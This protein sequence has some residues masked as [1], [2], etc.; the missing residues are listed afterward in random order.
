MGNGPA[1]PSQPSPDQWGERLTRRLGLW[2]AVAVL[3]GS[4]IGSGI[5]RT[6]AVIADRVPSAVPML[7]VWVLGGLLALCGAL[8]YAELGGMF[9]RS[10][11][12]FVYIK[13]SFGRLPAFL[14][15]WTELVVIRASALGAIATVFA[16]YLLRS[17]GYDPELYAGPVHYVAAVA[18]AITAVFNYTGVRW[19]SL[20]VN[21]TTVAKYGALILLVLVA[22]AIGEG[23]FSH[24]TAREGV[25]EPRLFGLA[26]ISVLWAYDG[27]GDVSFVG[28]EVKDPEKTLPRTFVLGTLGVVAISLLVNLAY[29][30]V[31]PLA[32]I[33]QS[34]LVAADAAQ[35]LIG[36]VG[37]GLV[38]VVV[39]ISTFGT[40]A[41]SMLTGPRIFYAMAEDGLFFKG[42][43]QVHPRFGTP[44]RAIAMT[45]TLAVGFVLVRRFEALADTF[46]LA[47]WPFYALAAA[48]LLV[49]RRRRPDLPRP[50]RV[51]GYPVVPLLFILSGVLI[52][53]NAAVTSPRDPLIAF[54]VI[55]LGLP[56]WWL[57]RRFTRPAGQHAGGDPESA[58]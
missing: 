31:L 34:P 26:L 50:V 5:F 36:R 25:V 4:T 2:S 21:V 29:L 20:L 56:A 38:A 40:L 18:I 58:A 52:L 7:G 3:I 32:T 37:V 42:I 28:G 12:V 14:F 19:S 57:W 30:Y 13:E 55:V 51:L 47:I 11:G 8:T 39:M 45:A 9:P 41:G 22:F 27:W 17:L 46:I 24:Y 35:A 23:D 10:G 6:P 16:E 44:A 15:G 43:A 54:G 49:L 53:V 1:V 48:G 33:R